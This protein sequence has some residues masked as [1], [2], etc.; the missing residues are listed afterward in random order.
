MNQGVIR[1]GWASCSLALALLA[2][3]TALSGPAWADA[4]AAANPKEIRIGY[5]KYGTLIILKA[6]GTLEKRL[7][8]RGIAVKW[9]EFPFGPPLLEAINVGSLDVGTTG[10]APP[11]FA[12]AAGADIVY[13]GNEPAAPGAEALV[14][15]K[16]SPVRSVA[17]LRGRKIAV[18]K[19]SN[20]NYL[21]V[22][23]LEQVGLK[24]S[25]VEVVYLAPADARAAFES[26]RV[27]AWSI[28]D[29]YFS[30]AQH[31]IGARV[32]ADGRGAVSNHQFY[33]AA[34]S[35]ADKHPDIVHILLEEIDKIDQ[36][37]KKN[38]KDVAAFLAP[39][40][41]IEL[42]V[43]ETSTDRFG[44]GVQPVTQS[45]LAEQQRIA[46]AFLALKLI[47]KEIRVSDAQWRPAKQQ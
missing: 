28:W 31:Q 25:D 6:R 18:A 26:G 22:K 30:A 32:L 47:P 16:D 46:D 40:I 13:I 43:I 23:V 29:P 42:P 9:T 4:A 19:G 36:W 1:S 39:Q 10:E 17:E 5:Q 44:Y 21:L 33:L 24:Y 15:A 38:P 7:A 27:D 37:G 14:L 41:G 12:Q 20:A 45:I 34:R 11:I 8:D 35:F 3:G 2:I